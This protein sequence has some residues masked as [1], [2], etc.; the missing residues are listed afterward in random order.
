MPLYA[1]G[2]RIAK[3]YRGSTAIARA[4]RGAAKV[5]D[6]AEAAPA[7]VSFALV[8]S[9][10]GAPGTV[11]MGAAPGAGERRFYILLCGTFSS[12]SHNLTAAAL[13]GNAMAQQYSNGP[14]TPAQAHVSTWLL[15]DSSANTSGTLAITCS[16]AEFGWALYRAIVSAG[17]ALVLDDTS[18]GS[19]TTT[20]EHGS[21]IDVAYSN[22]GVVTVHVQNRNGAAYAWGGGVSEDAEHDTSTADFFAAASSGVLGAAGTL[23]PTTTMAGSA[24]EST[25]IAHSWKATA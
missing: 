22:G 2:E 16:R 24:D 5:F 3:L 10:A 14:A 21:G 8:A 13:R 18:S 25:A 15:E 6:A 11:A 19:N 4:Y 9:G 17:G 1:G 7:I 12:T 20:G 23:S